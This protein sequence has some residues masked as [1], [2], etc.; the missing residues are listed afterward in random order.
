MIKRKFVLGLA[1]LAIGAAAF[2]ASTV[3]TV[4]VRISLTEE[5]QTAVTVG[6]RTTVLRGDEARKSR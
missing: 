3:A 4:P 6:D 5:R 1:A 2:A